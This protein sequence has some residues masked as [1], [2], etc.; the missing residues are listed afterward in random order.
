MKKPYLQT[1]FNNYIKHKPKNINSLVLYY[2]YMRNIYK[3]TF[4]DDIFIYENLNQQKILEGLILTHPLKKSLDII[5]KRFPELE[6]EIQEDGEIVLCGTFGELK[7][8]I[9]LINNL[10]YFISMVTYDGK[11][12][13]RPFT[14]NSK[15]EALFLEPKYDIEIN[16]IPEILYHASLM[17][18]QESIL[19]NGLTPRTENKVTKHPERIYLTDKL[20]IAVN[21]GEK[22][23]DIK[24]KDRE[25]YVVFKIDAKKFNIHLYQDIN[26]L[27]GGYYTIDNIPN[28][29]ITKLDYPKW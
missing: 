3:T 19:K 7:N 14:D 17:R 10:G 12:W 6:G 1:S 13:T 2:E 8:Y 24:N 23:F 20:H 16:P 15:P 29:R 26:L 5:L 9:P 27:A 11:D 21:F 18:F 4:Q 22:L 28:Y 25:P